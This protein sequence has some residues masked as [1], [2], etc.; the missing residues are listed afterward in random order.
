MARR[1]TD[2]GVARVNGHTSTARCSTS[3]ARSIR[4]SRGRPTRRS[5]SPSTGGRSRTSAADDAIKAQAQKDAQAAL[6]EPLDVYRALF[7]DGKRS[8]G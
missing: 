3:S 5:T 1:Y 8:V 2:P 4:C 6:A 7:L